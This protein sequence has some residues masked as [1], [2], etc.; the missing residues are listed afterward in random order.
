MH[1][2]LVIAGLT[3][4][5]L[6]RAEEVVHL[7][8][9]PRC[10]PLSGTTA[11]VNAGIDPTQYKTIVAFGDSYTSGGQDNGSALAPAVIIPPDDEAGG[12]A[13]NGLL[14]VEHL[15]AYMNNATL[16][17]YAVSGACIDLALWP[18]NPLPYDFLQQMS[19][20]LNQSNDLDPETTLYTIFFGINDYEASLIDGPHMVAAAH[21]LVEQ[22]QILASPPTNGRSFLVLDDYGRGNHTADG[23]AFKQ[24]IFSALYDFHQNE[25]LQLNVSFL[26][27]DVI[28]DG[29]LYYPP[30]Y[31]AFGYTST[32]ACTE[33]TE[34]CDEY[35]W[36]TDP[37]HYFYWIGGHP[38]RVT[39][40][41]MAQFVEE[42]LEDCKD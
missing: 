3:L 9:T 33:C 31:R 21:V 12:R 14:W 30:G 6:A 2:F 15:A 25:T 28:W 17:D 16:M 1:L 13:T 38:S 10:G 34:N 41:I 32:A 19:L 20:F 35:G 27:F 24:T 42:V 36:C 23:E 26:S 22:I 39:H 5:L 18:S 37:D 7:A 40:R 8:V 29:V 4:P 11:D